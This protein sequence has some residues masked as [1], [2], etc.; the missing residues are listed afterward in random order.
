MKSMS[1]SPIWFCVVIVALM[2]QSCTVAYLQIQNG[3]K[4]NPS[5]EIR[6]E[7][8][9]KFSVFVDDNP[10]LNTRVVQYKKEEIGQIRNAY[11]RATR[12][13]FT[14]QGCTANYVEKDQDANFMIQVS[15]SEMWS[16]LPQEWLT[17]LSLGLIPSWGTRPGEYVFTF[18][19]VETKK[20]HSYIVDKK[21]F[22]HLILF[23]IFWVTFI[24]SN[25]IHIYKTALTNFIQS[26]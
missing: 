16:A 20:S 10:R 7:C 1:K 26:S 12:E 18:E 14:K 6:P 15:I 17:G 21:S 8:A 4:T 19:D 13:V 3:L 2:L 23:P 9:V 11:I 25:Q 22:N 5:A 24:T